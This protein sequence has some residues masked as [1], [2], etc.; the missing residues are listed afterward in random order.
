MFIFKGQIERLTSWQVVRERHRRMTRVT[1]APDVCSEVRCYDTRLKR[2][3]E[4]S[5]T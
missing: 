2:P 4:G 1:N 5:I 3:Q